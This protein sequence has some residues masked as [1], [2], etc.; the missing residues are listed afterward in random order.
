[1]CTEKLRAGTSEKKDDWFG[2]QKPPPRLKR[3]TEYGYLKPD[4]A[5]KIK[6]KRGILLKTERNDANRKGRN[7]LGRSQNVP[8]GLTE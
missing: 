4:K 3:P 7:F 5:G 1:V 2:L 6:R 8:G